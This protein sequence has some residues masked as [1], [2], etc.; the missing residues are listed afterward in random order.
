MDVLLKRFIFL[1]TILH[2][3]GEDV[4]MDEHGLTV[5]QFERIDEHLEAFIEKYDINP[6][7]M[8]AELV[9]LVHTISS[10]ELTADATE[11]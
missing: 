8:K 5:E 1:T 10:M 7:H 6:D 2:L 9:G 4:E 11:E 3:I